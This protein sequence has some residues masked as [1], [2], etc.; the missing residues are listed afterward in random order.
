[1]FTSG[2][3]TQQVAYPPRPQLSPLPQFV[4]SAH[5]GRCVSDELKTFVVE[6]YA[7]GR[8]LRQIAELTARTHGA[9]RN[10]LDRAGVPRRGPGADRSID[11]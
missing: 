10:I 11:S 6:Q 2:A 5:P 1:M 4:G 8:S 3:H 7:L 9:V